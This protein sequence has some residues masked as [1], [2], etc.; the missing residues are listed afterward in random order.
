M[1]SLTGGAGADTLRGGSG[2]DTVTETRDADFEVADA[3]LTIGSEGTDTLADI[4]QADLAGGAG[5]N[6]LDASGFSGTADLAGGEGDDTFFAGLGNTAFH[7]G[8][9]NDTLVGDDAANVWNISGTDAGDL[10][11]SIFDEIENLVG[12]V[13]SDSFILAAGAMMTGLVDGRAGNDTLKGGNGTNSWVI[14]ALNQGL[15][16]GRSFEG[17]ENLE[18]GAGTDSFVNDAANAASVNY[19]L[20][21]VGSGS[22]TIDGSTVAFSG[23][24]ALT[25]NAQPSVLAVHFDG[26]DDQVILSDDVPDDG[27]LILDSAG[28][29][30]FN[31]RA[32]LDRL[33]IDTGGGN[34]TLIVNS[35]D[36]GFSG[37]LDLLGGDGSDIV[38]VDTAIDPL[39]VSRF[40]DA[41]VFNDL[42]AVT[43]GLSSANLAEAAG[44]VTVTASLD[45]ATTNEVTVNL[46]FAGTADGSDYVASGTQ[47][48]I[49]SGDLSGSITLSS[50]DNNIVEL[51]EAIDVQ[52]DSAVNAIE[53]VDQQV[54]ATVFNDDAATFSISDVVVTEGEG[55]TFTV[56]L[57][58]DVDAAVTV[59]FA[60]SDGSAVAGQDYTALSGTLSFAGVAGET[61]TFTVDITS[62]DI[63]EL[64]E[65]LVATLSN[66]QAG[67]R[68]V[69]IA[70][71]TGEATV[72]NDDAATL[73]ISDVVVTEG[74]GAT[75]TVTLDK[76]VDATVTIDFGTAD[77][78]AVA[79]ADYTALSGTL[80]FEGVAGEIQTFTVDITSEDIVELS[81]TLVATLSN[82]QAGGRAVT[83]ADGTGVAA[84]TNDDATTLSISDVSVIEGLGATFTV[85]LDGDVD[86]GVTIDFVTADGSAVAGA[87]YS[88]LSGTLSFAGTAGETQTFTVDITGEDV[89]ELSET[90]TAALSNIQASGRAVTIADGTG[91]ATVLNDDAA[92]LSI[93]DVV[94]TEG[95]GA[96]FT[97]TLDKDVD[98]TVTVDFGTADGSAVAGADYTALSGT[99]SFAGTAGETQ[100]FTVDITGENI[101]ELS[102]TLVAT[103]ANVQA[104]GR[105]V[106]IGDGTGEA[107]VLNDDA[108]QVSIADATLTEQDQGSSDLTFTVTL[109]NPVD[110]QVSVDFATSDGSASVADGDYIPVNTTVVFA[111]GETSKTITVQVAGDNWFEADEAFFAN[112][113]SLVSAGRTVSIADAQALGTVLNDD[114]QTLVSLDGQGNL[115]V[116]DM[117]KDSKADTLSLSYDAVSGEIVITDASNTVETHIGTQVD[118]HTVRVSLTAIPGSVIVD[119][120]GS[121]DAIAFGGDV[122]PIPVEVRSGAGVDTLDFSGSSDAVTVDLG[123]MVGLEFIIG[124]SGEDTLVG[125]A[126]NTEWHITG[127]DSGSVA[128]VSFVGFENLE[129]SADNEDTFVFTP[130]G[131]LSGDI[132]GGDVGFD[133]LDVRDGTYDVVSFRPTGPQSGSVVLDGNIIEY[134]GLE[135]IFSTV[136]APTI[137]VTITNTDNNSL[138]LTKVGNDLVLSGTGIETHYLDL[139][140]TGISNVNIDLGGG[141]DDITISGAIDLGTINLDITAESITTASGASLTTTGNI[142]FNAFASSDGVITAS[143]LINAMGLD[144]DF[145]VDSLGMSISEVGFAD[146]AALINLSNASISANNIIL[147][148]ENTQDLNPSGLSFSS[149]TLVALYAR[150]DAQVILNNTTLTATGFLDIDATSDVTTTATSSADSSSSDDDFD[151]AIA[152]SVIDSSAIA[153]ISGSSVLTVAGTVDLAAT[154]T[155]DATAAISSNSGTSAGASLAFSYIDATTKAFIAG[156]ATIDDL[157]DSNEADSISIEATTDSRVHTFAES[158]P[159]GS[160]EGSSS[161]DTETEKKLDDYDAETSDGD[162]SVA[163]A[164]AITDLISDTQAYISSSN[165]VVADGAVDI[166]ATSSSK[167]SAVADGSITDGSGTTGVGVGVAIN[168]ADV[169]YTAYIDNATVNAGEVTVQA[170]NTIPEWSFNATGDVDDGSAETI[171]IG[172]H[173][174][175]KTGDAVIYS[176]G[177]GSI[178][179]LKD[180]ATYYII[181]DSPNTVKLAKSSRDAHAGNAIDLTD[182]SGSAHKLIQKSNFVAEATSGAG[183]TDVGVAGSLGL[184]IVDNRSEAL[185]KANANVN[186]GAGDVTLNA[187]N[188]SLNV[189]TAYA[190][191][192]GSADVGVGPSIALNVVNNNITRAKIEDTAIVTNTHDVAVTAMADHL[193][194]TKAEAGAAG[195]VAFSPSVAISIVD[196]ETIGR[197]GTNTTTLDA[198]GLVNVAA[199]HTSVVETTADAAA[200]GSDVGVGAAVGVAVTDDTAKA[201]IAGNIT[202]VGAVTAAA[203]SDVTGTV[204]TKASAKGQ[205]S[206]SST[207]DADAEANHSVND[208]THTGGQNVPTANSKVSSANS[209]SS[210]KAGDAT[211]TSSGSSSTSSSSVGIAA[212]VAVNVVDIENEASI[213]SGADVDA[214]GAVTV[215]A[216]A[217]VDATAKALG[218]ATSLG[219]SE[220]NNIAAAVGLNVATVEN[221]AF[222]NSGSTIEGSGITIEA[223]TPNTERNDFI[224]WGA[225]AGGGKG[226]YAF[227]GSVGINIVNVSTEAGARSGSILKSTGTLKVEAETDLGLQTLAAAAGFSTGDAAVGA[228]VA[229]SLVEGVGSDPMTEAYIAGSADATGAMTIKAETDL[230]PINFSQTLCGETLSLDLTSVAIAGGATAGE[231][232][233]GAAVVI[234]I[235]DLETQAYIGD[236]AQINQDGVITTEG[237]VTIQAINNTEVVSLAG[238]LGVSTGAAGVGAGLDVAIIDKKTEAYIASG[239]HVNSDSNVVIDA[240]SDETIL[241]IAANAGVA[242]SA[243]IAASVSVQVI[244]TETYAYIEDT[245][246]GT[247]ANV[248]AEGNITITA[249][250]TFS[251]K[252][253]AGAIGVAS[254]AGIGASNTTLIHTDTVKAYVGQRAVVSTA[255]S[256]GLSI[257]AFSSEDIIAV[258]AAGGAAGTA[259]I[260]GSAVVNVLDETTQAYIANSANITAHSAGSSTPDIAVSADDETTIVSVAGTLA[261]A[262]TAGV[263]VGAD[264]GVI[265]KET[266]AYIGSGVTAHADGDITVRADS[267]ENITSVAAGLAASGTVSIALDASVHVLDITTRAFIGS[268][269]GI[270]DDPTDPVPY[271]S[272]GHVHATGSIGISADDV[273]EI[274]KVVGVF[275]ASGSAAI[276]AA[277][278]VTIIDKTTDAF[279]GNNAYV[280]G[281]G[282]GTGINVKSGAFNLTPDSATFDP[283]SP[284]SEGIDA[285]EGTIES[286]T[287]S[288]MSGDGEVSLPTLSADS[289]GNDISARTAAADETPGFRGVAVTATNQDDI[290]VF[291]LS[292]AGATVGVAVSAGVNVVDT[293][294]LAHIDAGAQ[295]NTD[296]AGANSGQNVHIAAA[297]D[298]YHLAVAGTIAVGVVGVAPAVDVTVL[299]GTTKAYIGSSADINAQNDITVSAYGSEE[300]LTVAFGIA[301]GVV[302][303]GGAVNVITIDNTT[304]AYIG[305]S[306]DV[307]AGGDILVFAGD[308]T[309]VTVISGAIAGGLVGV[310]ASVGVM[311][312]DKVTEAYIADNAT[313]DA[314]GSGSGIPGVLSGSISSGN[315]GTTT[316]DGLVVQ[317]QSSEDIFHLTVAGGAGFVGVSGTVGVTLIDSDT[318][319]YIGGNVDINQ[320]GG[321]AGADNDQS[322]YVVAGNKVEVLSTS[323]GVAGGFV[324]VGGAVNVGGIKNDV[325]AGI[326]GSGTHVTAKKD[327]VVNALGIKDIEGYT[328]SGAGGVVGLAAGVSVWSIGTGISSSYENDEG[329]SSNAMEGDNGSAANDADSQAASASGEVSGQLSSGFSGGNRVDQETGNASTK[330][331]NAAPGAGDTLGGINAV[332]PATVGTEA[333]IASGATVEAGEDI[334][335]R[336]KDNIKVDFTGGSAAGGLV[337]LGASIAVI[338]I[339]SNVKARAAGTL[340]ADGDIKVIADLTEDI[341]AVSIAGAGGFV[342]LGA[343]VVVIGE[344]SLVQAYIG[345]SSDILTANNVSVTAT[346]NQNI[347]GN[348][349]QVSGGAVAAGASFT[350]ISIDNETKS[351]IGNSVDVGQTDTVGSVAVSAASTSTAFADTFAVSAGIGAFST[352]FAF[353]DIDQD[354][355]AHIGNSD[356]TVTGAVSVTATATPK[357]IAKTFGVSAGGLAVGAS[358]ATAEVTPNV[359]AYVG[360]TI[361]A[362]SLLV[363]AYQAVPSGGYSAE[364][365]TSGSA[366]GLVGI[367]AT[368]SEASNTSVVRS[369]V[370]NNATLNISGSTIVS[371]VNNSKQKAEA[372]SNVGGLIA[373]GISFSDV[374]SNATTHAY[375]GTGVKL[376][377]TS[378]SVTAR[379]TDDNYADTTAGA[380]GLAGVASAAAETTTTSTT[381]AEIQASSTGRTIRLSGNFTMTAEHTA[382]PNSKVRSLGGG[383]FGG[384]GAEI[385]NTITSVVTA[386][387]GNYVDVVADNIT[388][389]AVNHLNKTILS[390]GNIKGEAGGLIS[391]G[392]AD[393]D[394]VISMTTTVDIGDYAELEADSG[395]L[396]LRTL[397]DIIA[398]DKVV[399]FAAGGL[400]GL[401]ADASIV[402]NT[403]I[404]QV[405]I[406]NADLK[407]SGDTDI[408]ARGQGDIEVLVD[409]EAYGAGTLIT[410]TAKS[411]IRPT[412]TVDIGAGAHI[413]AKGDL[414]ISAGTNTEFA[415]DQYTVTV[416]H[417]SFA[418]SAIP[419][420]DVDADAILIQHNTINI[421]SGALLE[422]ARSAY[423]HTERL[424]LSEMLAKAKAVN[425]V[426]SL[427][428]ALNGEAAEYQYKGTAHSETHGIVHMDGTVRTGIERH[429]SL[430]LDGG[431]FTD[432]GVIN[433]GTVN[434]GDVQIGYWETMEKLESDLATELANA[435]ASLALYEDSNAT[436]ANYYR[437]EIARLE[438]LMAADG[439]ITYSQIDISSHGFST[440]DAV[441]YSST[442]DVIGG[443]NN[444]QTYYVIVGTDDPAT[445]SVDEGNFIG[446]A[447]SY[448]NATA[449]SPSAVTMNPLGASGIHTI[450]GGGTTKAFTVADLEGSSRVEKYVKTVHVKP[451]WAEAGLIDVRGDALEGSGIFDAP[452][453]VSVEIE[454]NTPAFLVIHGI[455][456]PERNG[457]LYFTGDPITTNADVTSRN[458]FNIGLDALGPDFGEICG[459]WG[460]VPPGSASFASLPDPSAH[461]PDI[462][463]ENLFVAGAVSSTESYPW[464]DITVVGN[465]DNLGGSVYLTTLPAGEGDILI[466]ARVRAKN[467]TII[468]GGTLYVDGV[469]DFAVGGEPYSKFD[470]ATEETITS[471]Y[472]PDGDGPLPEQSQ[473][474]TYSGI[475]AAT[476]AEA[477]AIADDPSGGFGIADDATVYADKIFINAEYININGL[478]Q[479]GK[480]DYNLVLGSA[481]ETEIAAISPTQ[482]AYVNLSPSF[483]SDF[484]VKFDPINDQIIVDE[485]RVSGGQIEMT[486][487]MLNT[488]TGE[489]RVLGGY[490]DIDITNTT[491]YDL[492]LNR[493]DASQRGAGTLVIIDKAKGGTSNPTA[494]IYQSSGNGITRTVDDGVGGDPTAVDYLPGD[495]D[496]YTP[497]DG[498]RY[499][500]SVGMETFERSW[501][502]KISSAWL[503]LDVFAADPDNISW[504]STEVVGLPQ[505][506]DEGPYYYLDLAETDPYTHSEQTVVLD[507]MEVK[508]VDHWEVSH[509][510]GTTDYHDIFVGEEYVR[511]I[512]THT[513]EADRPF[514]VRFIGHEEGG[515]TV[516]SDTDVILNGPVSN[517]SGT[518]EITS[519]NGEIAQINPNAYVSGK[520]IDLSADDGIGTGTTVK[521][522][523][524][525]FYQGAVSGDA[526]NTN[527][528]DGAVFQYT[529]DT[530][531]T[532]AGPNV[533]ISDYSPAYEFS[534]KPGDR[535][536]LA[537]DYTYGGTAGAVYEYK[538]DPATINVHTENYSNTSNW[539]FVVHRPSLEATTTHGPIQLNEIVGDLHVD[540]IVASGGD[541]NLTSHSGIFV[542]RSS[543]GA[544]YEGLIEGGAI[545]LDAGGATGTSAH[546]LILESG[547]LPKD[548]VTV[549]SDGAVYFKEKSGD[550]RL[551][552][553]TAGGAVKVEVMNG[554]IFDAN[555][556]EDIDT[557]TVEELR[558]GVWGDL[559]LTVSTGADTKI[560]TLIE[561][562]AATKEKEY[563]SYWSYRM[564]QDNEPLTVIDTSSL[565]VGVKYYVIVDGTTI[566]LAANPE[567]VLA[568]KVIDLDATGAAGTEHGISTSSI[569][570]DLN[571]IEKDNPDEI[572]IIGHGF[573]GGEAVVYSAEGES[574]TVGATEGLTY[575]VKFIDEDTIQLITWIHCCSHCSNGRQHQPEAIYP[576]RY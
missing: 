145:D 118:S 353:V 438:A 257:D 29:G 436:L 133:T 32:P 420:D 205:S 200:A 484:I 165:N 36:S 433:A 357:A 125:P 221:R 374:T 279:I 361:T 522:S 249:D 435:K 369:Y 465:I 291:T 407:S 37:A 414:N 262:G 164:L 6:T 329:T 311:S 109:D 139:T 89:V 359:T 85:T 61:Q 532:S 404:S 283:N 198:S 176:S 149:I 135:P 398:K 137:D 144:V 562:F 487:H 430:T 461:E 63:V 79:G 503:D 502:H 334:E 363:T 431:T 277:G 212:A 8:G 22:V 146:S 544:Y 143:T 325:S 259:A 341:D 371:S 289:G 324:G 227:A 419:L 365:Y 506:M 86:T 264:V 92:T 275:A 501:L 459:H 315:F 246:S 54:A 16:N 467:L 448:A 402:A 235:Y 41:E 96:T 25:D 396:T 343:A 338:N 55:A 563:D 77:G 354:V 373:A 69:T 482:T 428:D 244:D 111:Q 492:V 223:V 132:E 67:G 326:L 62:E 28:Y 213:V 4:E 272:A 519:N 211:Q 408:S 425:W 48:Q 177:G 278:G 153:E 130:G 78:S 318:K 134:D 524:Q 364:A 517:P 53:Y 186:A 80:S 158:T 569:G 241:S 87:D 97:V 120:G 555:Q 312:I 184:N 141:N 493:L 10:N 256:L 446:L 168:I 558:N 443:L 305:T 13:V 11:G 434:T 276:G 280:I 243:G 337:G 64:S 35:L 232:G 469:T 123:R 206:G 457:G 171:D 178:G 287:T 105:A 201:T 45:R 238:S 160:D 131:S 441:V 476:L 561:S 14:N 194:R 255:E 20:T 554:G 110:A 234:N 215:S 127:A 188:T 170:V 368:V 339:D 90:L 196:N 445:G 564:G 344:T 281:D 18:G 115:V 494:T 303:I 282:N 242:S 397:N 333:Y 228:A 247:A 33:T 169:D 453:D 260:A 389:E 98:A 310:G 416:R 514:T 458:N 121:D 468:A 508:H 84:I 42:P 486:G 313:V 478:M 499:G 385:D 356:I 456:I 474:A 370:S 300:T 314:K 174:G 122:I 12:G 150:S 387:I 490:G 298:F 108:A 225:A 307:S 128:G 95:Q 183:A 236:G 104:G 412:N 156:T 399:L 7:G 516:T 560:T 47:I 148:A 113:S 253:I 44:A 265:D 258:A 335:V 316:V 248:D 422:T 424:G 367:D 93:S 99:L 349:G 440:G 489:I 362:G 268:F 366:G 495:T 348:T 375:L 328:F 395:K 229:I 355:D 418:G 378:L 574:S 220:A 557:R 573:S 106:T 454:N 252:M 538:G 24:E 31:F 463:V 233:I 342:G 167:G 224:V 49:A 173:D 450:T 124:S 507:E 392:G 155:I 472:D 553:I 254:T 302:G 405:L 380:I 394:T 382:K 162:L 286:K 320:S 377:G 75:F 88:A 296:A 530:L 103:L 195:D 464:P 550:L 426:S 552:K 191:V 477:A 140:L 250:A 546:P 284:E 107:T 358:F 51:D 347:Y 527:L 409:A 66:V 511:T 73:S 116:S 336:A 245:P 466:Q 71:D 332:P 181:E 82:V 192:T 59:D 372:N 214:G 270:T 547:D 231:V 531:N 147:N 21:G 483:D 117:V 504:D 43:L 497:A 216:G 447:T 518:T 94:V 513:I 190:K 413:T 57:D 376:T 9:G 208:N 565:E 386:N 91:E 19:D 251:T 475:G 295:V 403:D 521:R 187:E 152:V 510:Y 58:N 500:W 437:S 5:D 421:D 390:G 74:Q 411:I 439:L 512:D 129:G 175:L 210:T 17:I 575:Y 240:D 350:D 455:T 159:K 34:D 340:S 542:G 217:E 226:D 393:S 3:F 515:I 488:G 40:V 535:V 294:T 321:N 172:A 293:N 288:S 331:T 39:F 202:A 309:E 473:T 529:T 388:I 297:S 161:G 299:S 292:F 449:S 269:A 346:T 68:A 285:S 551:E 112:I 381:T 537:A 138:T 207:K 480:A 491:S 545:T 523:D 261:V 462:T 384:A 26:T 541:I 534:L 452:S 520:R 30:N 352:N 549:T 157:S 543:G 559:Q 533:R 432:G 379:G 218:S 46:T 460:I 526:I 83:I 151:A 273:T 222:V 429:Q 306:A 38:T 142:T 391:A 274:D 401:F 360:G 496:T 505:L 271:V 383:L 50:L 330:I 189:A 572:T 2:T 442:G 166:I 1:M 267:S 568:G 423:L 528:T 556:V 290:E 60:T 203:T 100:T 415:R 163:A 427:T 136:A 56:T 114:A 126:E 470:V 308:D 567:D 485:M 72:L 319:A 76:D 102:E 576:G 536:K 400:S 345:D 444:G 301:A 351:Y 327:V 237:S 154:N 323:V 417:D 525:L 539:T 451:V 180:G 101:V 15:L 498:W 479:S 322:V 239:A 481:I 509:W 566:Q 317:A 471:T 548:Q 27:F 23:M 193:V 304:Q 219:G 263:G 230:A 406:G 209:D 571:D 182:G 204:E 570:F 540:E 179:G 197:L 81:E 185:I 119:T 266:L 70:D 52:V 65:T 410:G 199:D